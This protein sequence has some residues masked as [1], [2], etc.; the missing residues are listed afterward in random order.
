MKK[1]WAHVSDLGCGKCTRRSRRCALKQK[2]RHNLGRSERN[3]ACGGRG[4]DTWRSRYV[5]KK[6]LIEMI[7]DGAI[8]AVLRLRQCDFSTEQMVGPEAWVNRQQLL[9]TPHH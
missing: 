9:K 1:V 4:R 3:Y 7:R 5:F 6:L 8:I 2:P